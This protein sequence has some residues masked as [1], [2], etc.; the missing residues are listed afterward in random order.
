M[1]RKF[2]SSIHRKIFISTFSIVVC[3]IFIILIFTS[4]IFYRRYLNLQIHSSFDQLTYISDQFN[5]Y[6][7]SISNYARTICVND[8]IQKNVAAYNRNNQKFNGM[9]QMEIKSEISRIIQSTPFI[10]S[11]AVY[12]SSREQ[13]ADTASYVSNIPV[14]DLPLTDQSAWAVQNKY[15]AGRPNVQEPVLSLF[16]L[17]YRT[18]TGYPIGYLEISMPESAISA[19]YKDSIDDSGSIYITDSGGLIQSSCELPLKSGC[20]Y[21]N[22]MP[23]PDNTGFF[24]SRRAIVF[25][26]EIP[27]LD[28]Y[29]IKEVNLV[30]FVEP[31]F[32]AFGISAIAG[33]LL[34]AACF[35][36]S[37]QISA[38][39]TEPINRLIGHTRTVKQGSWTTIEESGL[40]GSD[41]R[42]LYEAFNSMILAQEKLKNDLMDSEKAKSKVSLDLLQ[43]QVNPHFLYNTLDNICSLAEIDEKEKLID[44][45]MNLSSFYRKALSNGKFYITVGEE[46]DITRAYLHIMQIRYYRKFDFTITC[47]EA[48]LNCSCLKLLLQPIVENSIY[49]GI[50]ELEEFGSIVIDAA[51]QEDY[52]RFTVVDNGV[53]LTGKTIRQLWQTDSGHFGIRNIHK[54]IQ[55]YYGPDCGLSIESREERGCAVTILIRRQEVLPDVT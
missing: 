5:F 33:I 26:H 40:A 55:L 7:S 28:W 3:A 20:P 32:I 14:P 45:V 18:T 15:Q 41:I 44:L 29:I 12:S 47:E 46:L 24:Y 30:K 38:D 49:H 25:Y 36:L 37:F 16:Q 23:F 11:V 48:L 39:I 10:H 43:Q 34:T 8:A 21:G 54:R 31:A 2:T 6:L 4:G 51:A 9:D 1:L 22:R 17:F 27:Q 13:I 53:G 19:I 35:F 42:H 50:K 52:I